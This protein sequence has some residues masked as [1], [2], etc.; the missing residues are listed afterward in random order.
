M[1]AE[2]TDIAAVAHATPREALDHALDWDYGHHTVFGDVL[3][4]RTSGGWLLDPASLTERP[5]HVCHISFDTRGRRL[6]DT[7]DFADNTPQNW[8]L[9][10]SQDVAWIIGLGAS[11]PDLGWDTMPLVADFLAGRRDTLRVHIA[12]VIGEVIDDA[13]PEDTYVKLD[14][15]LVCLEAW[16]E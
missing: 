3:V 15:N 10:P 6:D 14:T 5:E 11:G 4:V 8:T 1:T 2:R 12:T 9:A 7:I 16:G 13:H